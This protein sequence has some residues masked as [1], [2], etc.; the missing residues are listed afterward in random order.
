MGPSF[1]CLSPSQVVMLEF[2]RLSYWRALPMLIVLFTG[3]LAAETGPR[4]HVQMRE[5]RQVVIAWTDQ[6]P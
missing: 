2:M 1:H 3:L 6:A 5:D 4:L